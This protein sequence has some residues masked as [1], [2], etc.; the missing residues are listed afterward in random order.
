MHEFKVQVQLKTGAFG[1]GI[2]GEKHQQWHRLNLTKNGSDLHLNRCF[3]YRNG[4]QLFHFF[5]NRGFHCVVV[6]FVTNTT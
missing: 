1:C 5:V 3:L 6:H 2:V 4:Q